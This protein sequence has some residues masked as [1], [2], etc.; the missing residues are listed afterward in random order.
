MHLL[1]LVVPSDR[2]AEKKK[3]E[4]GK[5]FS[6]VKLLSVL[7]DRRPALPLEVGPT[8]LAVAPTARFV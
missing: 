3:E 6:S 7:A 1:A 4:K 8:H 5:Q 2:Q